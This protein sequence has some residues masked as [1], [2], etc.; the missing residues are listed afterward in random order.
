MSDQVTLTTENFENEVLKSDI[1]VVVDFWAEWCMP[2]RM[3]APVL[4]DLSKEYS[5]KIKVGKLNVDDHGDIGAKYN[6]I[7]IPT[8]LVFKD[9]QLIKQHVGAA[10]KATI[11]E[12]ISSAM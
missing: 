5:G 7:S 12:L 9:G 3:I 11:Q 4:E 10:P 1:P 8:L 2:C 6:I